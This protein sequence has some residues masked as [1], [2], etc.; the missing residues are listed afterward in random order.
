VGYLFPPAFVCLSIGQSGIFILLGVTLFLYLHRSKPYLAGISLLLCAI[1]PQLFLPF[2][3]VLFAWI[4]LNKS[5]RILMGFCAALVA[6][7]ALSF[8]LAPTGWTDYIHMMSAAKIQDESVPTV[9]LL[10][11]LIVHSSAVWLQF[12]P[13]FI[14]SVWSLLYF[15]KLRKQWS[16][17]DQGLLLLLVS[18][19]V[20]P[21]AW[22]T[23]E[24]IVLPA[25]L[26]GLYAMSNSRRSLLPFGCIAAAALIEVFAGVRLKSGAYVW[27]T[28][29]W[30]VWYL[31]AIYPARPY[32]L[33]AGVA[34]DATDPSPVYAGRE[35][36]KVS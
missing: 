10:F 5:R 23:D 35:A 2:G 28:S 18:V 16:W 26:A 15:W 30:L 12:L 36:D 9:S 14:G 13:V 4:V 20:S 21:Y 3:L 33:R 7:L 6:S 17:T 27:T 29:A 31:Y 34:V 25:I 22:F 19:L 32:L 11:R 8:Y 24:V 1:K